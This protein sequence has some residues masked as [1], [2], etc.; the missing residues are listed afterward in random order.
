MRNKLFLGGVAALAV[1]LPAY[2]QTAPEPTPA[3]PAAQVAPAAEPAPE[4]AP[5]AAP[6][7]VPATPATPAPVAGQ[8]AGKGVIVMDKALQDQQVKKQHPDSF[9]GG[10]TSLTFPIGANIRDTALKALTPSFA[11]GAEVAEAAKPDAY[12]VVL[13][14]DGFT[15]KYDSMSSL[16][17]AITPRVTVTITAEALAP[18]GKSLFRKSYSRQD[19]TAGAY[20]ASF[21]PK[22]KVLGSFQ[23]A[24]DEIFVEIQA[25][26]VKPATADAA[27][28]A[29]PAT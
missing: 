19:F 4:P 3:A 27:V 17:F 16:G 14:L 8:L 28:A 22:E 1:G 20:V 7:A 26:L 6:A 25:D 15:Y 9:T 18:D 24:L 11:D 29:A 10:A 23:K 5:A 13:R 12:D 2:A 21:K